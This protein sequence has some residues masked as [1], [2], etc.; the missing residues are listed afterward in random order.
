MDFPHIYIHSVNLVKLADGKPV[1][2]HVLEAHCYITT[3]VRARFFCMTQVRRR[4]MLERRKVEWSLMISQIREPESKAHDILSKREW[5]FVVE[6]K[7][8]LN[9]ELSEHHPL[10]ERKNAHLSCWAWSS[11][12]WPLGEASLSRKTKIAAL[13][14]RGTDAPELV[15]MKNQART[16]RCRQGKDTPLPFLLF[17]SGSDKKN[18]PASSLEMNWMSRLWD[19]AASSVC[20]NI[21][22]T[23]EHLWIYP[24]S[25][26]LPA[27]TLSL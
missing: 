26:L 7:A 3:N 5:G 11:I 6:S 27:A 14:A 8:A 17:S 25:R 24:A 22:Q 12:I 2:V 21:L 4:R 13:I 10:K 15:C 23:N 20:A 9:A 16:E 1:P 18:P 19:S